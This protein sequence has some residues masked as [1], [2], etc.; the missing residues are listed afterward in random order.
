[1]SG[2]TR[3][4]RGTNIIH[5]TWSMVTHLVDD[6]EPDRLSTVAPVGADGVRAKPFSQS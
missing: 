6:I 2:Y 4:H 3:T 1:M 5:R